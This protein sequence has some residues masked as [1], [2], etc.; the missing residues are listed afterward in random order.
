MNEANV[1]ALLHYN[2]QFDRLAALTEKSR[3]NLCEVSFREWQDAAAGTDLLETNVEAAQRMEFSRRLEAGE[4][5]MPLSFS[6]IEKVFGELKRGGVVR[7]I[8]R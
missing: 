8:E 3:M 4:I 7:G 1:N 5:K 6:E 2:A